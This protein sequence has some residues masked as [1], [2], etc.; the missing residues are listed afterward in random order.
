MTT[1]DDDVK[2]ILS[3]EEWEGK[4]I[5]IAVYSDAVDSEPGA[6][7]ARAALKALRAHDAALRAKLA[8]R[9]RL[10]AGITA[11]LRTL[12]AQLSVTAATAGEVLRHIEAGDEDKAMEKI[13]V[14]LAG[15]AALEGGPR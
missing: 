5:T 2:A 14:L 6:E 4:V 12:R 15:L 8:E 7:K 3:D 13:P 10:L 11:E 9:D 1:P